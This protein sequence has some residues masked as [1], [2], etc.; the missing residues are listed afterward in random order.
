MIG[1]STKTVLLGLGLGLASAVLTVAPPAHAATTAGAG[2][3]AGAMVDARKSVYEFM[4]PATQVLQRDDSQNPAMLWVKDGAARWSQIE[5]ANGKSCASCHAHAKASMKG[6]AAK[7][8]AYSSSLKRVINLQQQINFCRGARQGAVPFALENPALLGLESYV[9][10]QS[11][12]MLTAPPSDAVTVAAQ[13]KGQSLFNQRMGQI[14]LSCKDCHVDLAGRSLAG[15]LIPQAH[16]TGYPLY[17]LAWQAVGGL[18][19]RLRNC[20]VGIRAEPSA[21]GSEEMVALE[22]YLVKRAAGMPLESPAVRP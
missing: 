12:G 1:K 19:R 18:Q 8:P 7:Y 2:A 22:A 17:R 9:A 16:P 20:L 13:N 10:F 15:N 5:G 3:G 21:F 11:R 6:V 4:L 14:D